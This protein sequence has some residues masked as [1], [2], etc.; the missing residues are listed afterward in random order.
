VLHICK[1]CAE[2]SGELKLIWTK[3]VAKAMEKTGVRDFSL[4]SLSKSLA[5]VSRELYMIRRR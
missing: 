2:S 5:P 4:P 3:E 1:E